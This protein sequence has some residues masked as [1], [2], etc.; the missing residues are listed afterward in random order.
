M[1]S[2]PRPVSRKDMSDWKISPN[3]SDWKNSGGYCISLDK[4]VAANGR[5]MQDVRVS[6]GFTS[7]SEALYVAEQKAKVAIQTRGK[8]V[9][10]LETKADGQRG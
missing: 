8:V 5:R 1:H 9:K 3:V 4:R 10:E 2:P 6:D 7:L